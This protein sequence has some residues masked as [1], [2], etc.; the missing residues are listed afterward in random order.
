M[1]EHARAAV[2][3]GDGVVR[4]AQPLGR[5]F[6]HSLQPGLALP[7]LQ[8]A[9]D[10]KARPARH[11]EVRVAHKVV[12]PAEQGLPL[13][14]EKAEAKALRCAH[15]VDGASTGNESFLSDPAVKGALAGVGGDGRASDVVVVDVDHF[16]GGVRLVVGVDWT[17][18]DQYVLRTK[19]VMLKKL[20]TFLLSA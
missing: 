17:D 16:Q 18:V 12:G 3:V 8:S 13:P 10:Y 1:I 14:G 11:G 6:D 2:P 9:S 7:V 5:D 19:N 20:L 15:P 4:G